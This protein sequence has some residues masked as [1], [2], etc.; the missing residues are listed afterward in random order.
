MWFEDLLLAIVAMS[1]LPGRLNLRRHT[2]DIVREIGTGAG[3]FTS[4]AL[5]GVNFASRSPGLSLR[6]AT[7]RYENVPFTS[8]CFWPRAARA[9][10]SA[11]TAKPEA[12]FGGDMERIIRAVL[13][14]EH[15]HLARV[16]HGSEVGI[17]LHVRLDRRD[18]P[19]PKSS[20]QASGDSMQYNR[21]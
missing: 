14:H 5:K 17:E 11:S 1:R 15:M 3:G 13:H 9:C 19:S 16:N 18:V 10:V 21:R 20:N 6:R 2:P 12:F 7:I 4:R 8:L